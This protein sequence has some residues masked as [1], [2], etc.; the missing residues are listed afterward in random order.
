[1]G[2]RKKGEVKGRDVKPDKEEEDESELSAAP[3]GHRPVLN[4]S[5]NLYP[6]FPV[7][8]MG[9]IL[10]LPADYPYVQTLTMRTGVYTSLQIVCN[11]QIAV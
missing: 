11:V 7:Q 10:H 3:M 4:I 9:S 5:D 2:K 8:Q 1:M 6:D